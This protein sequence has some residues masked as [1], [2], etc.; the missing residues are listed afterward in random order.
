VVGLDFSRGLDFS[1]V[2]T[3]TKSN[4]A[5]APRFSGTES[6]SEVEAEVRIESHSHGAHAVFAVRTI[7]SLSS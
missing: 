2:Y 4:W 7:K 5:L 3:R 1:P 6:T